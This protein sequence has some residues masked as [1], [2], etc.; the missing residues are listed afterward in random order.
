MRDKR[1]L[2]LEIP[3]LREINH[4]GENP[5]IISVTSPKK[6]MG[7]TVFAINLTAMLCKIIDDKVAIIDINKYYRDIA[8]YLS[9]TNFTKGLDEFINLKRTNMLNEDNFSRCFKRGN[10]NIHFMNSNDCFDMEIG[11]VMSLQKYL[12]KEYPVTTIDTISSYN[13]TTDHFLNISDAIIVVLNQDRKIINELNN[14][15]KFHQVQDKLLFVINRYI[16][17]FN[18]NKMQYTDL[19][20]EKDIRKAGFKENKIFSLD[21]DIDIIN[22]CNDS[23]ILNYVLSS[24]ES[25]YLKQLKEL[26][27]FLLKQYSTYTVEEHESKKKRGFF[28]G[29][30]NFFSI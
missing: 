27:K 14:L 2:L 9:N 25:D 16:E 1:L 12:Y 29:R 22:E 3:P 17:T 5:M 10:E 21:F 18:N 30:L 19:E 20:I 24:K 7:Q 6:G 13:K 23:S 15:N 4:K 8:Y 26:S 28:N 11:D